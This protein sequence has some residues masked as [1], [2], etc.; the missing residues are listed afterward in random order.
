MNYMSNYA[1]LPF[2]Q[3]PL[4][5]CY[6]YNA[7]PLSIVQG[8]V[9][10]HDFVPWICGKVCNC[11]FME[12]VAWEEFALC[13]NDP[14]C[15]EE[16]TLNYT[17]SY[18]FLGTIKSMGL[19]V[20]NIYKRLI[21]RG[22]YFR[23][24][25]SSKFIPTKQACTNPNLLLDTI[26]YGYD[27][28]TQKLSLVDYYINGQFKMYEMSYD[29]YYNAMLNWPEKKIT[30]Q[31]IWCNP[32]VNSVGKVKNMIAEFSDYVLS[33]SSREPLTQGRT[34][35]IASMEKLKEYFTCAE[36]PYLDFRYAKAFLEQKILLSLCVSY[37]KEQG[38]I[39]DDCRDSIDFLI[40]TAKE[41]Y[42]LC[43]D[44]NC[45]DFHSR[46]KQICRLFD[47]LI[48]EERKC[49]PRILKSI[50]GGMYA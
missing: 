11:V 16:G 39:A 40:S 38:I 41:I 19:D 29:D 35:G 32:H 6:G 15:K 30:Y 14:P 34:Y 24:C 21:R 3:K 9:K 10:W 48:A 22:Y 8:N 1:K 45:E 2:P 46:K 50:D 27:D 43:I 37:L 25:Y 7:I 20:L 28:D 12:N 42:T 17:E 26:L 23:I 31:V 49:L 4:I 13:T 36:T 5:G 44:R 47:L 33:T 18:I